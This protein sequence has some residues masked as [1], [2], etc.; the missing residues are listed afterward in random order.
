MKFKLSNKSRVLLG[1]GVFLIALL[2]LSMVQLQQIQARARAEQ[3]MAQAGLLIEKLAST[4]LVSQKE[5]LQSRLEKVRVEVAAE[6]GRLRQSL[7]TIENSGDIY[8][9]AGQ[10]DVTIARIDSSAVSEKE[11]GGVK[12]SVILVTVKAEGT[13]ADLVDFVSGLTAKYGTGV[14]MSARINVPD[15]AES[16]TVDPEAGGEEG[17]VEMP[18][19][20]VT[21]MIYD[22]RGG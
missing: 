9:I 19:I 20:T 13:V 21:L 11:I 12:C 22:Y 16:G 8:D 14:V 17:P 15:E 2:S 18:M 3:E 5:A 10:S 7:E 1:A 4:G 6:K